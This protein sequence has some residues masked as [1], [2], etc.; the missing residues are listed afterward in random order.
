MM[1][2]LQVLLPFAW[3]NLWRNSRRTLITLCVVAVGVWSILAFNALIRAWAD[4]TLTGSLKNLTAEAQIHARGYLDDPDMRK[5][6]EVPAGG[7]AELLDSNAV[8]AWAPRVRTPAIVRSEYETLPVTL[9]GIRPAREAG[10]SFIAEAVAQGRQLKG[11]GDP[12]VLLGRHLAERLKTGLGKRIVLMAN[13]ADGH[14]QERGAR[15]V[16]I[17][18]AAP[19]MEDGFVFTGLGAAQSFLKARGRLSEIALMTGDDQPLAPLLTR[20][21]QAAPDLEVAGWQ[22][23]EP[24]TKGIH[25][26]TQGFIVVWLWV[27]FVLIA[28]G[29]INTQLM[30]VFERTREFGLLQ[31]LGLRPGWVLAE[32]QLEAVLII[33][34]GV[35]IGAL[36]AVATV[37]ALHDGI[38]LGGLSAG[39]DF[40]GIERVLYPRLD[41]GEFV[42]TVFVVWFLGVLAAIWPARRAARFDPIEAMRST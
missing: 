13:D 25:D 17:F 21:R 9:L 2:L 7:L 28:I 40:L 34:I 20:L 31:A 41:P 18:A 19:K 35:V 24:M 27:M 38:S 37:A 33:G 15:V 29:V 26:L 6:F 8:K 11:S 23:L 14:M 10:V 16:G 22:Q 39:A 1:Q 5:S 32:V 30:A 4:S 36:A 3:R 42:V 12:G